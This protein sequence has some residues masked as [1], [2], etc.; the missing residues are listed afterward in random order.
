MLR[1]GNPALQLQRRRDEVTSEVAVA[2]LSH[3]PR[4]SQ[5]TDAV[6]QEARS[7]RRYRGGGAPHRVRKLLILLTLHAPRGKA[8]RTASAPPTT[9][10]RPNGE[11][12]RRLPTGGSSRHA[13]DED[14]ETVAILTGGLGYRFSSPFVRRGEMP[15]CLKPLSSVGGLSHKP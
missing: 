4:N 6:P 1:C 9:A 11:E 15:G 12:F 5:S 8:V 2:S 14:V 3:P 10:A 7:G 13:T